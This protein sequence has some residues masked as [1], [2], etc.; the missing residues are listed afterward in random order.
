MMIWTNGSTVYAAFQQHRTMSPTTFNPSQR[1]ILLAL[2]NNR[3]VLAPENAE[4]QSRRSPAK[5]PI[6]RTADHFLLHQWPSKFLRLQSVPRF[7][8]LTTATF[9]QTQTWRLA[10]VTH[11]EVHARDDSSP[12]NT[13]A[14]F[15]SPAA[16][17]L[18]FPKANVQNQLSPSQIQNRETSPIEDGNRT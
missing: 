3:E 5:A 11:Q 1:K 6:Q 16:Q 15:R 14:A 8:T 12:Q 18:H 4:G 13:T 17:S 7:L 9:L 2:L 10:L